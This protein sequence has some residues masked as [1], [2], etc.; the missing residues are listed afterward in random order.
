MRLPK[1]SSCVVTSRQ[2]RLLELFEADRL[3]SQAAEKRNVPLPWLA[4]D[5]DALDQNRLE[6]RALIV[7]GGL[8]LVE[9]LR[10]VGLPANVHT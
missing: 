3:E 1:R 9:R 7:P 2:K 6:A 4:V 8:P 5:A 10:T